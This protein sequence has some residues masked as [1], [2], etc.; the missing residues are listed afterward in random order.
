[1]GGGRPPEPD[2]DGQVQR[3]YAASTRALGVLILVL[4]VA[5]VASTLA[6]GGGAMTLGVVL[7]VMLTLIGS[8]RL[9]LARSAHTHT[10]GEGR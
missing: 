10:H 6:R 1:L 7:G 9:W 2:Y 3:A 4:G 5:M 8:G